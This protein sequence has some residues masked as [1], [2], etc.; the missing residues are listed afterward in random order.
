MDAQLMARV[1]NDQR[2][3]SGVHWD[4]RGFHEAE[5]RQTPP[6]RKGKTGFVAAQN[7]FMPALDQHPNQAAAINSTNSI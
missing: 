3:A 2:R 6:P 7:A 1:G 5:F 4:Y